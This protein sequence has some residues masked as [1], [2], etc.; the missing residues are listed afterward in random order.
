MLNLNLKAR[1]NNNKKKI[2][3]NSSNN[4]TFSM[5]LKNGE[6]S[7]RVQSVGYINGRSVVQEPIYEIYNSGVGDSS[8]LVKHKML[9]L[10]WVNYYQSEKF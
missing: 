1:I 5:D 10:S 4:F 6:Q 2:V 9:L 8:F 3:T 7:F